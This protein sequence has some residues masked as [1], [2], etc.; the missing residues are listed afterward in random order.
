MRVLTFIF[1]AYLL[2]LAV[3]PC[4]DGLLPR[5]NQWHEIQTVA[6]LDQSSQD[7]NNSPDDLCSPFCVCSCCGINSVPNIVYSVPATTFQN[8]EKA[9]A[10]FSQ[11]K[12]P[13]ESTRSFSIWQPPKA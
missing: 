9:T 6:H 3:Q 8:L 1:V 11:Y 7:T 12:S 13:Y 5:D 4:K 10:E 2:V